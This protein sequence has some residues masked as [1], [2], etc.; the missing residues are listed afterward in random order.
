MA[1]K[2]SSDDAELTGGM[3]Y[4]AAEAFVRPSPV[5]TAGNLTSSGFDLRNCLFNIIVTASKPTDQDSPTEIF[6]PEFH[7]PKDHTHIEASGGQWKIVLDDK[8]SV[9]I[10]KL[11]WWHAE[12][13]QTLKAKGVVRQY[14]K[15]VD[16]DEEGYLNH[17]W[18]TGCSVM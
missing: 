6:L 13:E 5:V 17:Y 18:Q 11:L 9:R 1:S 14:G 7:F 16:T 2:L 10:Q 12:G 8:S 3:G 15:P 4:R